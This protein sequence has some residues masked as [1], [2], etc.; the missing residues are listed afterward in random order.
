[1]INSDVKTKYVIAIMELF[2]DKLLAEKVINSQ[3]KKE[4]DKLNEK[5]C[6]GQFSTAVR[7]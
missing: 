1:M 5:T 7:G 4:L 6:Y 3:Q 2:A